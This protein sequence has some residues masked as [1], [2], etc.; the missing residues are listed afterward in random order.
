M[1]ETKIGFIGCGGNAGGH[2]NTLQNI[3][4]ANVVATCDIDET[5][6][7]ATSKKHNATPY[8]NHRS[9]L[10]APNHKIPSHLQILLP[11]MT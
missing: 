3:E 10:E 1:E 5:R 8:T 2:M 6:A 11:L 9:M 7:N 4:G